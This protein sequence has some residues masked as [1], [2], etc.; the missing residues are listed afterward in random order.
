M[1]R[2]TQKHEN[3][4]VKVSVTVRKAFS[5]C[6]EWTSQLKRIEIILT[7]TRQ[8]PNTGNC[9]VSRHMESRVGW[10]NT[11]ENN[12]SLFVDIALV[13]TQT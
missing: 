4:F 13:T 7:A 3:V 9:H 2:N 12:S 5:F 11:T 8:W 6:T 1:T 10:I